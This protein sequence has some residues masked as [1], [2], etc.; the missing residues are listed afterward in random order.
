MKISR[1]KA[2][3]FLQCKRCFILDVLHKIKRPPGFPF[4]INNAV[5]LLL[6]KE[7]D[8]YRIDGTMHPLQVKFNINAIPA[9]HPSLNQW[10]NSLQGGVEFFHQAS[11]ITLFGGID[12]LWLSDS[13]EYHVVDYK[14]TARQIPV[15]ALPEWAVDYKRQMEIYQW[16]LSNNG[17]NMSEIGYFLYCTGNSAAETFSEK[18]DFTC[19][20][21]PYTGNSNW[22][23]TM[24]MEIR[25]TIDSAEIPVA[26]ENCSWCTFAQK[27][28]EAI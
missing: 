13:G 27:A 22:I 16:L 21:I 15:D 6:K 11:G 24:L 7:F 2:E 3:L 20:I 17:L 9:N 19:K 8:I 26:N 23:E 25:E 12:D 28:N 5:D 18:L 1:S 14:A 10:R 4:S